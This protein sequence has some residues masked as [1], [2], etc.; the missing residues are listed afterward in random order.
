MQ[1]YETERERNKDFLL[2]DGDYVSTKDVLNRIAKIIP[3][4]KIMAE[5]DADHNII[6][7]TSADVKN[8]VDAIGEGLISI[9]LEGKHIAIAAENSYLYIM[10][11]LAIAGGVGVVTP[12]DKDAPA[13][14]MATLLNKCDAEAI[15]ISAHIADK[16]K[17]A[18]ANCPKLKTIITIDQK[19]EG[20]ENLQELMAKG[21]VLAEKGYYRNKELD[22][23]APAKLLFTSGTTGANKGVI[24]TQNN[25]AANIM[26]CM[27]MKC[28]EDELNTSM[29]VL[30]MHHATEINTHVFVRIACGRLTYINDNMKNMM[31]NM[32]I[33]KPHVITIVPMIANAFYR[34][35]WMN[36][37]KMGMEM[38]LKQAI[39]M[40]NNLRQ[41]GIDKTHEIFKDV[42]APF[43]GNLRQIVCGGAMLNPEVVKG[44]NDFGVFIVNGYGITECGPLISMNT[45]TMTEPYSV[46]RPNA[47]LEVKLIDQNADGIGELCVKGKS[48][49]KGYYKDP[50]ATAKVFDKDGF[51]HT[52]DMA[53]ID[54]QGR[55]F[56]AGRQ[57]NLIVLANGKN[58][59]PEELEHEISIRLPYVKENVVY[60]AEFENACGKLQEGICAG[61][62]VEEEMLSNLEKIKEDFRA[63]NRELPN[64]KKNCIHTFTNTRI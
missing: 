13:D 39:L 25:L 35:I 53:R 45:E 48:V 2:K 21:R 64:H 63:L 34:T 19:I 44:F 62:V 42:L 7:H 40:S 14:L 36:V 41:N 1:R 11:D 12:I 18:Q 51:F 8:D 15:I 17:A 5:L 52:G 26:N 31:T 4:K 57:K 16:V 22:L 23:D 28:E 46:G 55:I 59:Y 20:L 50:E 43:G 56:L 37:R 33:F 61:V 58:I 60:M 32:R 24:L 54:E 27:E 49:S 30:P 29:S 3:D 38:Q 10:C 47:V 9:G 6:Y